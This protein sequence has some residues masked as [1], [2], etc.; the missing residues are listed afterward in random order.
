MPEKNTPALPVLLALL[1]LLLAACS[2]FA[3]LTE[4]SN[5][6]NEAHGPKATDCGQCHI[7]QFG[8]WQGSA[9][10]QAFMNQRFQTA[11]AD[12]AD[13]SCLGPPPL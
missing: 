8:E 2:P 3:H 1:S 12:G 4:T 7:E 5:A 11:L 13:D 6:L 10:A 9:H